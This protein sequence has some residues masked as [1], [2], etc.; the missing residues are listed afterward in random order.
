MLSSP[1]LGRLLLDAGVLTQEAL[2]E[3]LAA[4]RA[5][6]RRLGELLVERGVATPL[7]LAQLLSRQL[8]CPWISL[9]HLEVPPDVVALLPADVFGVKSSNVS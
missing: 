4:Q 8:S 1:P 7:Q 3:V 2:D 5:D 6:K 9:A